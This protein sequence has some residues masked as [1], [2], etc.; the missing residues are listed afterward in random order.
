LVQNVYSHDEVRWVPDLQGASTSKA[1]I[2]IV[3]SLWLEL[4]PLV[5]QCDQM[6]KTQGSSFTIHG[7]WL[8]GI[9]VAFVEAGIGKNRVQRATQALIEGHSPEWVLS[10]GLAGALSPELAIEDIFLANEIISTSGETLPVSDLFGSCTF[11]SNLPDEKHN[12]HRGQL[13][14]AEKV[15]CTRKEKQQLNAHY[16]ASVVE[17]ESLFVGQVCRDYGTSFGSVRVISDDIETDLPPE[18]RGLL[19]SSKVFRVGAA[20]GAVWNRPSSAQDLWNLREIA[21][22]ASESLARFICSHLIERSP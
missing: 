11:F 21:N 8:H 15:V 4:A 17:M 20:L 2:G 9:R 10:I 13:L 16:G 22:R 1:E 19:G 14:C 7:G 12:I 5:N 6:R 18:I 3:G